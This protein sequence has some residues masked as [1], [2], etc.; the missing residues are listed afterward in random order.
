MNSSTSKE[1]LLRKRI[2]ME[3]VSVVI[4]NWNGKRFL[5]ENIKSLINQDYPNKEIIMVDN[6]SEDGSVEYVEKEFGSQVR[7][8]RN[9]NNGY[10]GGANRGIAESHGGFVAIVNP[11][12]VFE[13]DYISTCIDYFNKNE[14]A[15]AVSGKLL[16]YDFETNVKKSVI[17]SAGIAMR[18]NRSAYD[19]GQNDTDNGQYEKAGRVFA[20]CGAAPVYRRKSLEKIKFQ[21]EYFDEDFFAYKEDIDLCWRF[22]WIGIESHYVPEAVAYHGRGMNSSRGIIKQLNNRRKQSN[23]LKGISFRNQYLMVYKNDCSETVKKD[24]VKIGV[25][26]LQYVVYFLIFEPG[27]LKYIRQFQELKKNRFLMKK[28]HLAGIKTESGKTIYNLFEN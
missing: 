17:D 6:S 27:N 12:I 18:R 7:I 2:I 26:F 20:V 11:D 15:G 24:K 4:V 19:I 3:K 13:E 16:K 5:N 1:N 8:I 21:H 9:I 23:Y 22:N 28:Q 14:N 25:R 10:A